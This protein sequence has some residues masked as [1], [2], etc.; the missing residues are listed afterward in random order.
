MSE[1]NKKLTSSRS[2]ILSV[3][4]KPRLIAVLFLYLP[5]IWAAQLG[6]VAGFPAGKVIDCFSGQRI[7]TTDMTGFVPVSQSMIGDVMLVGHQQ[8]E[9]APG[10]SFKL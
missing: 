7:R 5:M 8:M 3:W 6:D 1:Q 2:F 4:K 9:I 10:M